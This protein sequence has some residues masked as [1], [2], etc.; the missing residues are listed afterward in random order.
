MERAKSE[1]SLHVLGHPL[2]ACLTFPGNPTE[3][4][5]TLGLQLTT[6]EIVVKSI[7]EDPLN[8]LCNHE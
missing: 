6:I 4:E 5:R 8:I 3:I 2:S 1:H 7:G